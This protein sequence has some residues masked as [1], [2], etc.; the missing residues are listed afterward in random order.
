MED[1]QCYVCNEELR[2]IYTL[3]AV[4]VLTSFDFVRRPVDKHVKR[5][6]HAGDGDD[7]EG[8]R[9][10][11]LPPLAR[12]HLELLPLRVENNGGR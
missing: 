1:I 11:D 8:D 9:A 3:A 2:Y 4:W 7:V 12:R 5:P 6:H 10:Q